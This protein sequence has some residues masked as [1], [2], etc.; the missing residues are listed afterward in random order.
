M[1]YKGTMLLL[2]GILI[3][4]GGGMKMRMFLIDV[5]GGS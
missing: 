4:G 1:T 2:G 5:E 3:D